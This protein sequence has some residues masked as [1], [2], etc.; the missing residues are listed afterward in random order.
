MGDL[1][2]PTTG[3]FCLLSAPPLWPWLVFHLVSRMPL[4]SL[5]R[6]DLTSE[7]Q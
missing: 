4:S 5:A 1:R 2:T 7:E 3:G 6:G